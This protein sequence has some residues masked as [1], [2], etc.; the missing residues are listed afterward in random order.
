MRDT[1]SRK[2]YTVAQILAFEDDTAETLRNRLLRFITRWTGLRQIQRA[3][4]RTRQQIARATD[5][6]VLAAVV[7][8]I[9]VAATRGM[10]RLR[11]SGEPELWES[12][13][14][15]QHISLRT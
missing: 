9:F 11:T 10:A 2:I 5:L 4:T 1:Q 13:R 3:G 15:A 12:W 7:R 6:A 8:L 14:A